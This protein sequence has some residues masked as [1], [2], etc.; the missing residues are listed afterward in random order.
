MGK[1]A[2]WRL[3]LSEAELVFVHFAGIK[4][5][6]TDTFSRE[7]MTGTD[8]TSINGYIPVL[9]ITSSSLRER[10]EAC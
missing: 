4:H 1:P 6:E 10:R 7:K 3:R 9:R 2:H 8:Q 5:Q